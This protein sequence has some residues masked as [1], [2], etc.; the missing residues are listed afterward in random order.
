M[1][2][3]PNTWWLYNFP[4]LFVPATK[5][6]ILRTFNVHAMLE[7]KFFGLN[8]CLHYARW[9]LQLNCKQFYGWETP[10]G[11]F[12]KRT[13][14]YPN[15]VSRATLSLNSCLQPPPRHSSSSPS[16]W[17]NH[18]MKFEMM[19][20]VQRLTWSIKSYTWA[21][22]SKCTGI[23]RQK[24]PEMFGKTSFFW[25]VTPEHLA[26]LWLGLGQLWD[27]NNKWQ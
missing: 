3:T 25:P 26:V 14:S 23:Q 21:R 8:T 15:L 20:A 13:C 2:R 16:W 22:S 6:S 5:Q 1:K 9:M 10:A 17:S 24:Q 19:F 18:L 7:W 11:F 12:F 4:F 27:I